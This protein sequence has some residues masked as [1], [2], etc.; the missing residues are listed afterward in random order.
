MNPA[1][2]RANRAAACAGFCGP[3][4]PDLYPF[5]ST[6]QGGADARVAGVPLQEQFIQGGAL[7]AF[8]A[9]YGIG[10]GDPFRVVVV[11]LGGP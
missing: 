10:E 1:I 3:G 4:S 7:R 9:K 11:G 8:Y 6:L 5:A 2:N